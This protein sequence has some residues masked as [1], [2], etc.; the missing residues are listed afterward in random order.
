LTRSGSP[1]CAWTA[2]GGTAE[3]RI[4]SQLRFNASAQQI[5]GLQLT[6]YVAD[7]AERLQ[8]VLIPV[9]AAGYA[10]ASAS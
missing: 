6:R 7:K 3:L 4:P 5:W 9:S 2:P 10:S 8:W 1:A